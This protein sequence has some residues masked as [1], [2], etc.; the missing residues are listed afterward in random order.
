MSLSVLAQIP[1]APQPA[2]LLLE[3]EHWPGI[4]QLKGAPAFTGPVCARLGQPAHLPAD[5]T[6]AFVTSNVHTAGH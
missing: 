2:F 5:R 6:D 1:G 4:N 3:R